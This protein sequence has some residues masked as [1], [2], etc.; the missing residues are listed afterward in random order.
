MLIDSKLPHRIWAEALATAAYITNRCPTKAVNG[1]TPYE[2]LTGVRPTLEHL[3]VFSCDAFAHIPK[4][5]RHKLD[6]K[7]KKCVLLGYG[8]E[9]KGYRL[10]NPNKWKTFYSRDVKFNESE[11]REG[12]TES[13]DSRATYQM[14]LDFSNNCDAHPDTSE[15]PVQSPVD[16]G[17]RRSERRR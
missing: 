17:P 14:E 3:R 6:S 12:L 10:Y 8:E 9:T 11:K 1:M 15:S 13:C 4:D 16:V 2:A 7:S 5:E